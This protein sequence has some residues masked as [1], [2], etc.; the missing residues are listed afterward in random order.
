MI[1]PPLPLP[2]GLYAVGY[3]SPAGVA[4]PIATPGGATGVVLREEGVDGLVG[5]VTDTALTAVGV[6]G[7]VV[8]AQQVGPMTGKLSVD[9]HPTPTS[10]LSE[11][12]SGWRRAWSHRDAGVLEVSSPTLGPLSA[13]VRLAESMPA[14][15][16]DPSGLLSLEE[17]EV[18]VVCDE[19]VWFSSWQSGTGTVQVVNS[20][21]ARVWPR[22]EWTGSGRV[23]MPSGAPAVLPETT[24]VRILDLDPAESLVVTSTSGVPDYERW[25]ALASAVLPE[26][27]PP[28]ARRTYTLPAGATLRWRL[29][30]LDPWR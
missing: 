11:V 18:S 24:A 29:A 22:I 7:Q 28:G 21:D 25:R 30:Y 2:G 10:S 9:L 17:Q 23:T 4:W 20:G 16:A 3:T 14:L 15:P 5:Q 1:Y 12:V 8:D 6:P 13:R 19:G 27:V 26:G